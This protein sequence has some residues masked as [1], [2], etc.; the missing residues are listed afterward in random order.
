MV[1]GTRQ[2]REPNFKKKKEMTKNMQG[3]R[4]EVQI[5]C[6]DGEPQSPRPDVRFA[7]KE[8]CR[9]VARPTNGSWRKMKK[10]ARC[11]KDQP[12]VVHQIKLQSGGFW[13]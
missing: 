8:L 2:C 13:H 7:V 1:L 12:N 10:L 3:E 11:L 5:V 4:A 9:D 6:G